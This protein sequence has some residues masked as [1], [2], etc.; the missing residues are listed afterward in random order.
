MDNRHT[1]PALTS[2]FAMACC[3]MT[4]IYMVTLGEGTPEIYYPQVLPVYAPLLYGVNR[5]FLRRERTMLSTALLNAALWAVLMISICVQ[6]WSGGLASLIAAAVFTLI[7]T[8][9]GACLAAE[10]TSLRSLILTL[11]ATALLL[12]L[13]TAYLAAFGK[14][15]LWS[16]P[17]AA[18][19]AASVLGMTA[20]RIGRPM[21]GR[22]WGL[23]GGTF[24]L[25][26]LAVVLLVGV[27]AAPVGQGIVALWTLLVRAV[28][29]IM[30][31]L[32]RFLLFL[33]A[34]FPQRTYE[35]LPPEPAFTPPEISQ[36]ALGEGNPVVVILFL[37]VLAALLITM[38]VWLARQLSR[39]R[40]GGQRRT[41]RVL[42]SRTRPS[43]WGALK[44]LF[45]AHR[46]KLRMLRFLH[47]HREQPVGLYYL[48]VRRCR[49]APWHKRP[50][51]TPREFL[52]RLQVSAQGDQALEQAL[53]ELI[54]LVDQAL[55][56]PAP[57]RTSFPR[58]A[59]I[60][61][62]IGWAARRQFVRDAAGALREK[63][64]RLTGRG[65]SPAA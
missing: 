13:F 12:V 37:V 5:L 60:R 36:E 4:L 18:G 28:R 56:A 63:L 30:H 46:Q 17:I 53:R 32:W 51:E 62:R 64:A 45:A 50:G 16:L 2:Q 27:A 21:G 43:L 8:V 39:L 6:E 55:Y 40:I 57:C 14:S 1:F 3:L 61:R 29:L 11:D 23:V 24:L 38:L 9:R 49:T 42:H 48:L 52:A 54:P 7:I 25:I 20:N 31:L 58:A 15:Y 26:T 33:A 35:E 47:R 10:G 22:E 19:F 34:L 44:R 65:S 41:K 59:L